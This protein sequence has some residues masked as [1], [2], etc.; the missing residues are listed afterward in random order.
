MPPMFNL[1]LLTLLC[2]CSTPTLPSSTNILF[3]FHPLHISSLCTFPTLV[4]G[5]FST[6]PAS[7]SSPDSPRLLQLNAVGLRA[8][9][10]KLLYSIL[11][12]PVDLICIQESNINFSSCVRMPRYSVLRSARTHSRS[13][14]LSPDDQH[15]NG[16][17]IISMRQGLSFSELSISSVS[18]SLLDP[19]PNYVGV[20]ISPNHSSLLSFPNAYAFPN[21]SS[22]MD[23]RINSV[24]LSTRNLSI[25]R[26]PIAITFSGT[27]KVLLTHAG[28]NIQFKGHLFAPPSPQ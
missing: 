11:L 20:I 28:R 18:L 7:S 24:L 3:S 13:G 25:L 23:S 27:Q 21:C 12:P 1:S 4:S 16:G 6:P 14:I 22:L 10:A 15:T 26:I 5:C 17:V 2:Q 8:T 9:S 19:Y